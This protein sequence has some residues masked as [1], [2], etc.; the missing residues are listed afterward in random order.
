MILYS[1]KPYTTQVENLMSIFSELLCFRNICS[2]F[3]FLFSHLAESAH[4]DLRLPGLLADSS[5]YCHVI[6]LSKI[7]AWLPLR[8]LKNFSRLQMPIALTPQSFTQWLLKCLSRIIL[9]K[10]R[11][12][13][14]HFFSR[15]YI[16]SA[17]SVKT[18]ILNNTLASTSID[19]R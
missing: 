5:N 15:F 3:S 8:A 13:Q 16:L 1:T 10:A 7:S 12:L 2:S 9:I 4:C 18:P 19:P 17:K 6:V 14:K 11:Y